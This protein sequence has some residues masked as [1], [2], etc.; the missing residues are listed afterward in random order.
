MCELLRSFPS[1][2]RLRSIALQPGWSVRR[3]TSTTAAS[4]GIKFICASLVYG[5]PRLDL[6]S[7][8][9]CFDFPFDYCVSYFFVFQLVFVTSIWNGASC[10]RC[11]RMLPM[12]NCGPGLFVHSQDTSPSKGSPSFKP[13]E[14]YFSFINFVNLMV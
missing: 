7:D 14:F 5:E 6:N 4:Q 9:Y 3:L 12:E 10:T 8:L 2:A 13:F 1:S 11:H